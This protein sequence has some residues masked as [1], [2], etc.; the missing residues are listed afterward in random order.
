M[1][2]GL[3]GGSFDPA[4]EGHVHITREA[5]ARIGLDQVWWLVSPGNPL[6]ERTPAPLL[7]RMVEARRI[8]AGDTRVTVTDIEARLGT[9]LTIDTIARLQALC[10]DVCFVWLMGADNLRD[11]HHWADWQGI[12][13]RIPVAVLARPGS[14]DAADHAEAARVFR[15][16]RTFRAADLLHEPPPIW[17]FLD[18]PGHTAS[19]TE[20]RARGEWPFRA[21]HGE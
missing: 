6:K 12:M 21:E 4:H 7:Q 17:A 10:P 15:Q 2:V 19:S 8:L 16:A 9:R 14:E 11:F 20:I 18:M 13:S 3:L 1:S 5:I